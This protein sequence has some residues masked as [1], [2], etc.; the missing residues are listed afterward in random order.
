[1]VSVY[2]PLIINLLMKGNL[3]L[4]GRQPFTR[5]EVSFYNVK[6]YLQETMDIPAYEER[7]MKG[8]EISVLTHPHYRKDIYL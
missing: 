4:A 6:G 7:G 2:N 3:S 1:M 8:E 5:L